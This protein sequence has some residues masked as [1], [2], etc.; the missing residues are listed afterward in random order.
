MDLLD[1][2]TLTVTVEL[3]R[4]SLTLDQLLDME[5]QT[6][7]SLIAR[8][9]KLLMFTLTTGW[10]PKVKWWSWMITLAYVC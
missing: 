4:T 7:I 6:V 2:I 3:G 9:E 1:D 10:R 5:L 8:L